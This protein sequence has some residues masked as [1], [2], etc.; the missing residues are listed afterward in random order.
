ML[1]TKI[2]D[3]LSTEDFII[4]QFEAKYSQRANIYGSTDPI[5]GVYYNMIMFCL[6]LPDLSHDLKLALY[7]KIDNVIR[8]MEIIPT[9]METAPEQPTANG[10][11]F[12]G[13][14]EKDLSAAQLQS[15]LTS[16]LTLITDKSYSFTPNH[17][18]YYFAYPQTFGYLS[19]IT[20]QNNFFTL[21]GWSTRVEEFTVLGEPVNFIVYEF[22]TYTTQTS[23]INNFK[24]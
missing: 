6:K 2:N 4:S 13:S 3:I 24:F 9:I 1:D 12:H 5:V 17:E 14:G 7:K 18:V 11:I 20:D 8:S 15:T 10:L 19:G 16:E 23:F 21:G 22:N